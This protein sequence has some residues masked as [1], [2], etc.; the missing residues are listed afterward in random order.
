MH[1]SVKITEKVFWI[2]ANDRRTNLFENMWPLP[3]GV[4]YNSYL[5]IDEKI[6]LV[7]TLEQGSSD[8]YLEKIEELIGK[9]RTIDYLI[10]NHMEP[11]HS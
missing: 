11:D 2:G 9:D 5:I 8:D 3:K 10:I 4:S 7:D 1:N 6:A